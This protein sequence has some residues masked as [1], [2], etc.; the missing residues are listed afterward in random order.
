MQ[1]VYNESGLGAREWPANMR[2]KAAI[3][4]AAPKPAPETAAARAAR[5]RAQY[6]DYVFAGAKVR[7]ANRT[8]A[9]WYYFFRDAAAREA[10]RKAL[11]TNGNFSDVAVY[12]KNFPERIY[13]E[14]ISTIDRGSIKDIR[15]DIEQALRNE[16]YEVPQDPKERTIGVVSQPSGAGNARPTALPDGTPAV[17]PASGGF[18]NQLGLGVGISSPWVLAALAVGVVIIVRK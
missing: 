15:D 11:A 17:P 14:L 16:G 18:L 5:I 3:P 7:Y 13:V 6:P 12:G 2:Q 1:W 4:P 8:D 9:S 10:L